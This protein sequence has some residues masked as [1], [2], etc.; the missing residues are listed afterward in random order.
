MNGTI[1]EIRNVRLLTEIFGG[2]PSF[3]DSE[4]LKVSLA[5]GYR[6]ASLDAAVHVFEMTSEVDEKGKYV[7]KN[8]VQVQF[9]FAGIDQLEL[10]DFNHQN[11][12]QGLHFKRCE[13]GLRVVFESIFGMHA[14]FV[15]E[16][17]SIDSVEP[18]RI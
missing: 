11:V 3:H 16:F 12:L 9:H 8:H 15:C 10:S 18:F 2:F 1:N 6:G 5:R 17:A 7:L 13:T 4:V 14:T